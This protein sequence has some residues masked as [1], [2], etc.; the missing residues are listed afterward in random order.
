MAEVATEVATLG[1]VLVLG[2]AAGCMVR[3][4]FNPGLGLFVII[5]LL[6]SID[7]RGTFV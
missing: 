7:A 4:G 5:G 3:K 2:F 1:V 6:V